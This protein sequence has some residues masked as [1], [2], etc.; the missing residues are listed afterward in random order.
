MALIAVSMT[1]HR[2]RHG[3]VYIETP[4]HKVLYQRSQEAGGCTLL[5][6]GPALCHDDYSLSAMGNVCWSA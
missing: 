2:M 1:C 5:A 6:C 4:I 3:V